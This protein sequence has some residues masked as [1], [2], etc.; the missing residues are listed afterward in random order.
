MHRAVQ[1]P[2]QSAAQRKRHRTTPLVHYTRQIQRQINDQEKV[3]QILDD[4]HKNYAAMYQQKR[5]PGYHI[6]NRK[7]DPKPT[8]PGGSRMLKG[9]MHLHPDAHIKMGYAIQFQGHLG[10]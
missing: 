7:S 8:I 4:V 9:P 5:M 1:G 3:Q 6:D 10:C 2:A